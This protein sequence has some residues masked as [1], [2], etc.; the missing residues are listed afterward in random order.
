M[1]RA[2]RRQ[3]LKDLAISDYLVKN[4]SRGEGS[5]DCSVVAIFS[6]LSKTDFWKHSSYYA[7]LLHLKEK[8]HDGQECFWSNPEFPWILSSNLAII[9]AAQCCLVRI[10]WRYCHPYW[11]FWDWL[12]CLHSNYLCPKEDHTSEVWD[13]CNILIVSLFSQSF[14]RSGLHKSQTKYCVLQLKQYA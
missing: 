2:R 3:G 6:N 9:E 1:G 7:A 4:F 10:S 13:I 5:R 12:M 11:H 14:K 8:R